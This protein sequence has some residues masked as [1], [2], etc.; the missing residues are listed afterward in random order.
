ML[1]WLSFTS[2]PAPY[3]GGTVHATPFDAQFLFPADA[4]G[5][6]SAYTTWPDGVPPGTDAWFQFLVQDPSVIWGITLSNAV[7]ATTP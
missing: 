4:S 6:F 3:F 2:V 5:S 1:A 7:R